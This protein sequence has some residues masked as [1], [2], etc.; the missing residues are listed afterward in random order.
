MSQRQPRAA[1]ARASLAWKVDKCAL[2]ELK[3]QE[4]DDVFSLKNAKKLAV[5]AKKEAQKVAKKAAVEA[6]TIGEHEPSGYT[7][8]ATLRRLESK[9]TPE[10]L[11]YCARRLPAALLLHGWKVLPHDAGGNSSSYSEGHFMYVFTGDAVGKG[12]NV[13]FFTGTDSVFAWW[14][15][16]LLAQS[17]RAAVGV[18]PPLPRYLKGKVVYGD[19]PADEQPTP[20]EALNLRLWRC[21]KTR[22]RPEGF[23]GVMRKTEG[24]GFFYVVKHDATYLGSF[25]SAVE[26]A[27]AF[28]AHLAARGAI[29]GP[30]DDPTAL[31]CLSKDPAKPKRPAQPMCLPN[32]AKRPK[33][34]PKS[35]RPTHIS[36]VCDAKSVPA[37]TPAEQEPVPD[38]WSACAHASPPTWVHNH[39]STRTCDRNSSL[40]SS[41]C[42]DGDTDTAEIDASMWRTKRD[43]LPTHR[44]TLTSSSPCSQGVAN[45]TQTRPH[46]ALP[47]KCPFESGEGDEEEVVV[48]VI[49]IGASDDEEEEQP[50]HQ[51]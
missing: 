19:D 14:E 27:H 41:M 4:R 5:L 17:K 42:A 24:N 29:L 10:I 11:D 31:P 23:Q 7:E 36:Q 51:G 46:D 8:I 12:G 39:A 48:E 2:Q 9:Y 26:A 6:A 37:S 21:Q 49:A 45:T 15:A 38:V 20:V 22:T 3:Q 30:D 40:T 28:A 34:K 44:D 18:A 35:R 16:R 43:E 25:A 1:S 13:P 47:P 32:V 33:V 50:K